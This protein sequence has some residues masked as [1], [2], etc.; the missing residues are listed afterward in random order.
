MPDAVVHDIVALH[1]MPRPPII[2]ISSAA[3]HD[4]ILSWIER[5]QSEEEMPGDEED[6]ATFPTPFGAMQMC[7]DGTT[8]QVSVHFKRLNRRRHILLHFAPGNGVINQWKGRHTKEAGFIYFGAKSGT[9]VGMHI[10]HERRGQGLMRQLFAYYV[11][12]CR[13]YALP[14]A[15]T[16]HNKKPS[17]AKLF[18]TMGYSPCCTDF[19]FLLFRTEQKEKQGEEEPEEEQKKQQERQER[20]EPAV[21]QCVLTLPAENPRRPATKGKVSRDWVFPQS[22]AASQGLRVVVCPTALATAPSDDD[23]V[24]VGCS[25]EALAPQALAALSEEEGLLGDVVKLY[26]KTAWM[27]PDPTALDRRDAAVASLLEGQQAK[28]IRYVD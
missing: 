20:T 17:F 11:C 24:P 7:A 8:L 22:Y 13:C 5:A 6:F 3:V 4:R 15:D 19:P 18:V 25:N 23:A 16:A 2:E 1:P 10:A 27:L 26:A 14:A 21:S 9:F 28:C 12:F